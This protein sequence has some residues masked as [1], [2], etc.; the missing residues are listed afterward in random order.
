MF[1]EHMLS[2]EAVRYSGEAKPWIQRHMGKVT[3]LYIPNSES[4]SLLITSYACFE[5]FAA[6]MFHVEVFRVATP[7]SVVAG[8]G[9]FRGPCCLPLQGEV[10]ILPHHYTASQPITSRLDTLS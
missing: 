5:A 2:M 10:G 8:Y 3:P 4:G 6:V 7:R 1:V 9:R